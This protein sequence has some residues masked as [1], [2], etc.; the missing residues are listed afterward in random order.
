M[1]TA[2][3]LSGTGTGGGHGRQG[4]LCELLWGHD[5]ISSASSTDRVARKPVLIRDV[6]P[7]GQRP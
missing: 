1:G 7:K 2:A 3:R 6:S 5:A 4:L